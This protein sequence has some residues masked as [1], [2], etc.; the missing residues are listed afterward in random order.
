MPKD[1][2]PD[3]RFAA[4]IENARDEEYGWT[5]DPGHLDFERG[6]DLFVLIEGST[7]DSRFWL[8]SHPSPQAAM[9]YSTGQEYAGDWYVDHIVD[10]TT[11]ERLTPTMAVYDFERKAP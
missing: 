3:E 7:R 1:L 6:D 5:D 11:G 8:T 4:V 10:L 2:T 9:D